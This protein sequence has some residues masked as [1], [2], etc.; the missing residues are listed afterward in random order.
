[1]AV[2]ITAAPNS[3]STTFH[4]RTSEMLTRSWASAGLVRV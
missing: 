2:P 4:I 3:T 1:M